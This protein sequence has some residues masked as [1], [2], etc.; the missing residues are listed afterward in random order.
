MVAVSFLIGMD[1]EDF[2]G[3]GREP[4]KDYRPPSRFGS[5]LSVPIP[6]WISV[7]SD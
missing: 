4:I 7:Q 6:S 5:L 1:L 2:V 3:V